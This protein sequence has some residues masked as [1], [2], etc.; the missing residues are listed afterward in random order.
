MSVIYVKEQGARVEKRGERMLVVKGRSVLL[1]IPVAN[2]DT[3]SLIGRVEMTTPM[4]HV[5]MKSG[6]DVSYFSFGGNYIGRSYAE[7][8][9][10]IFL[11]LA[12]Y[13]QYQNRES[14]MRTA[15]EI[16]CNKVM[17][18]I[19]LIQNYRWTG[20]EHDWKAD[21]A[22]LQ[23]QRKRVAE[24]ETS[25]QLLGIEGFCSNVY[26]GAFGKMFR[27]GFTFNGRNRRPPRDPVNVILSLGYTFLTKEVLAALEAESFETYLGYLHGIR[28]GRKS[29]SLDIV[30][31]FRQPIIDRL[32]LRLFNKRM[33]HPA[34]F[35]QDGEAV[36][37]NEEGFRVFCREYEKWMTDKSFSG[38]QVSFRS[39]IKKQAQELKK[40][41]RE[42]HLYVPYEWKML[43]SDSRP[44]TITE[45]DC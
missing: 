41:I 39:L 12:Q 2:L 35:E 4:L 33:L 9:K 1:D 30:E 21:V 19:H 6:V 5:L 14:R 34:N 31:E 17:N 16:V 26:F 8:S 18:Q 22:Q 43:S 36:I 23:A 10:N 40:S 29:L 28:Y 13:E 44:L 3:V 15:K 27:G 37:L 7:S 24:M 38:C 45:S 32:V 20:I 11:R 25:S 42:K